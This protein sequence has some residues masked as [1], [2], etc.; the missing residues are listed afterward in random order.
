MYKKILENVNE[1][2]LLFDSSLILNYINTAGEVL[3]EDSARHLIGK[4][5]KT[6]FSSETTLISDLQHCIEHKESFFD[7]EL[8]LVLSHKKITINFSV[9]PIHENQQD[10]EVLIEIQ[11]VEIGRASC[12][13][14]V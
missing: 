6:L 5:A 4:H 7:R 13:E 11:Q 9:T 1:A 3:F 8:N 10:P 12:R 14:R 2:I